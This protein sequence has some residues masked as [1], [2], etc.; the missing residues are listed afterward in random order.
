MQ[1]V[2]THWIGRAPCAESAI[3]GYG[4]WYLVSLEQHFPDIFV[5]CVEELSQ[6]LVFGRVKLPHIESPSLTREDPAGEHDLDHIDELDFLAHHVL[7]AGLES[8]QLYRGTP[9]VGGKT[10]G[11]RVGGPELCV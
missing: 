10:G 9:G 3:F 5:R 1:N 4:W 6:R 2:K 7:H 11:S 8:G